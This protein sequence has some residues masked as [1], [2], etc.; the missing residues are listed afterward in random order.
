MQHEWQ[1]SARTNE[2]VRQCGKC[3]RL[4][5][6]IPEPHIRYAHLPTKGSIELILGDLARGNEHIPQPRFGVLLLLRQRIA[7]VGF[8]DDAGCGKQR[9]KGGAMH[10]WRAGQRRTEMLT[11]GDRCRSF[12]EQISSDV[13]F[14]RL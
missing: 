1:H 3:G 6:E 14:G 5:I 4:D 7:K 13:R 9:A 12:T 2:I 11:A 8:F 10:G